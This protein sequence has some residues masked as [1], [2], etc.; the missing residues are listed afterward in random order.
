M[1]HL[2]SFLLMTTILFGSGDAF[3]AGQQKPPLYA[4]G[5]S[6]TAC[7]GIIPR[8][9]IHVWFPGTGDG[10]GA[11]PAGIFARDVGG[12][13]FLLGV[14]LEDDY[15]AV[16]LI[17][18][19]GGSS[20]F[21]ITQVSIAPS[22][23]FG[24]GNQGGINLYDSYGNQVNAMM[25]VTFANAGINSSPFPLAG[26][27]FN[28]PK[29]SP[30]TIYPLTLISASNG[31]PNVLTFTSTQ[32]SSL[33]GG[34]APYNVPAVNWSVADGLGC[35]AAGTTLT[36]I[37]PTTITLSSGDTGTH[38][39]TGQT[40][41]FSQAP[42]GPLGGVVVP[43]STN[44]PAPNL[45]FSD[46]MPLVSV[47]RADAPISNTMSVSGTGIASNTTVTGVGYASVSI[48]P[49][50]SGSTLN[51]KLTFT[52]T[53]TVATAVPKGYVVPLTSTAGFSRGQIASGT[54]IPLNDLI[55]Q[56]CNQESCADP[57]FGSSYVRLSAPISGPLTSGQS[58]SGSAYA[59]SQTSGTGVSTLSI[60]SPSA[61]RPL[62]LIRGF[63]TG[64]PWGHGSP[65]NTSNLPHKMYGLPDI[66][67]FDGNQSG[68]VAVDCV[69]FV[70]SCA[71]GGG[72]YGTPVYEI[73][74]NTLHAGVVGVTTGDSHTG[75]S[76]TGVNN[77]AFPQLTAL[78]LSQPSVFP[79][80]IANAAYGGQALGVFGSLFW[81][82][83][84]ALDPGF[85][86]AQG[87][88]GNGSDSA[89]SYHAIM[90]G[91]R[92]YAEAQGTRWIYSTDYP[93]QSMSVLDFVVASPGTT[94]TSLPL[95]IGGIPLGT[96]IGSG[97][98]LT[99]SCVPANTTAN[100]IDYT[101]M[102]TASQTL[103]CPT[104]SLVSFG[105]INSATTLGSTTVTLATPAPIGGSYYVFGTGP[106]PGSTITL[107]ANSTSA[108]LSTGA[109]STQT[110]SPITFGGNE[111]TTTLFQQQTGI[112]LVKAMAG[113][114]QSLQIFDSYGILEDPENPTYMNPLYSADGLHCGDLC[115]SILAQGLVN[116]LTPM[117]GN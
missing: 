25:P 107:T 69:N 47:P 104:G 93:R 17:F 73:R 22:S 77:A 5:Q 84:K 18:G 115:H 40:I 56:V 6:I 100:L 105:T 15:T 110:S 61:P 114:M 79:V 32:P 88:T 89:S 42:L 28:A 49:P 27:T 94:S 45:I 96:A 21:T 92:A 19:N 37:T 106:T 52:Q 80:T 3:A 57:V 82:E 26:T 20:P 81:N 103:N 86:L 68:G 7:Q 2:A 65:N 43:A 117:I 14:E 41:Y 63:M 111:P 97:Y 51:Q 60:E 67:Q 70:G 109:A 74:Y 55:W 12:F 78:K 64:T 87:I 98:A 11:G 108:T 38:C 83:I 31:S 24:Y 58:F 39:A 30:N 95:Q 13:A 54:N 91:I 16:Q 116:L 53:G 48:S 10:D 34:W 29:N 35:V 112:G 4:C 46:W 85:V 75:G 72:G 36:N 8:S 44:P 71:F 90:E 50:T 59:A 66:Q 33:F 23:G 76:G 99:G 101:N 62:L 113:Q 1:K 102:L 9:H